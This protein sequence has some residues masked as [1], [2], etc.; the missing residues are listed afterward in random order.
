MA[1]PQSQLKPEQGRDYSRSLDLGYE[2][3]NEAGSIHCLAHGY[4]TPL[5]LPWRVQALPD[6]GNVG[7]GVHQ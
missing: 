1:T 2:P 7:Q 4:P 6:R 3:P 5:A